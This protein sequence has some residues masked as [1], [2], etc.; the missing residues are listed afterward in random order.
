MKYPTLEDIGKHFINC[1]AELVK[2][3]GPIN[4]IV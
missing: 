2:Y 3:G 1:A 4:T